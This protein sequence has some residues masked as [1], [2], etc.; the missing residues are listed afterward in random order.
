MQ[1]DEKPGVRVEPYT[2]FL[3]SAPYV[4][5]YKASEPFRASVDMDD[6]TND[7]VRRARLPEDVKIARSERKP[8]SAT[9][10][11]FT[12]PTGSKPPRVYSGARVI[13][14]ATRVTYEV[15][16]DSDGGIRS[17]TLIPHEGADLS[18]D[19]LDLD[20]LRRA[21]IQQATNDGVPLG[22]ATSPKSP[23][24]PGHATVAA[25]AREAVAWG[26]TPRHYLSD[27]Y[28]RSPERMDVWLREARQAGYDVPKM[29]PGRPPKK[30]N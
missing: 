20:Y 13:D 28:Q 8:A 21:A 9:P 19:G 2:A 23:E 4:I 6:E 10:S 1:Q 16:V 22:S 3:S 7:L 5:A 26:Q 11:G 12:V 30:S 18:T 14:D 29:K 24:R 15:G 25:L 17:L 27:R